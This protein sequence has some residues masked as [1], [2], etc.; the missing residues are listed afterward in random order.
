M[1]TEAVLLIKRNS[2]NDKILV[3]IVC[4]VY[5]NMLQG[6]NN[7]RT[8]AKTNTNH[9]HILYYCAKAIIQECGKLVSSTKEDVHVKQCIR[10]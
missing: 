10:M 1:S 4:F 6:E 9:L 2:V 3:E 8:Q 7:M 5:C